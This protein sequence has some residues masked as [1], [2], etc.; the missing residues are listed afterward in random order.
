M[1]NPSNSVANRFGSRITVLISY[2]EKYVKDL[3]KTLAN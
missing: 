2:I 3:Q 1:F